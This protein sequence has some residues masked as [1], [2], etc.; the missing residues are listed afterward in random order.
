MYQHK[1]LPNTTS[2][3]LPVGQSIMSYDVKIKNN[4]IEIC[5]SLKREDIIQ[6]DILVTAMKPGQRAIWLPP[7]YHHHHQGAKDCGWRHQTDMIY[8]KAVTAMQKQN[9]E[10]RNRP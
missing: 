7:W 4:N 8:T 3:L 9:K 2:Q 10:M 1:N 5:A 6:G